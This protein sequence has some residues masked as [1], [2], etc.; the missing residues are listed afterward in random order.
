MKNRFFFTRVIFI[1]AIV[2][3]IICM[4]ASASIIL[5]T[6]ALP[7]AQGWMYVSGGNSISEKS[8]FSILNLGPDCILHQD[9]MGAG[10]ANQ[11]NNGYQINNVVDPSKPFILN[12]RARVLEEEGDINNNHFGFGFEV[13]TGTEAFAIMIGPSVIQAL[14]NEN[15]NRVLSTSIDNTKF[16]NYRLEGTPGVGYKFYVDDYLV[17]MGASRVMQGDNCLYLGD[18]TGGTNAKADI[19][20]FEFDQEMIP[21]T[22]R[23]LAWQE[24]SPSQLD[25]NGGFENAAVTPGTSFISL[26]A[27]DAEINEW[28]VGGNGIDYIGGLWQPSEGSRS[29]DLCYLSNGAISTTLR[30]VPGMTYRLLFDMAGNPDGEP[31]TKELR[32]WIDK[33]YQDFVFTIAGRTREDMGW[34]TRSLEFTA[35]TSATLLKFESLTATAYGPALD[36]VRIVPLY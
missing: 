4:N 15:E 34:Q 18:G 28:I 25:I 1:S 14:D 33:K 12:V 27:G 6:C 16:H 17:A 21:T 32:V 23:H 19:A 35:T 13:G 20:S 22:E 3:L 36:N 26:Q 8:V 10:Q 5:N 30:T 29:I 11:G 24:Q 2:F 9:S 31:S 7:S